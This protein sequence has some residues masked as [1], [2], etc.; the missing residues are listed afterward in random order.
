MVRTNIKDGNVSRLCGWDTPVGASTLFACD[1]T[2]TVDEMRKT[3]KLGAPTY[4]PRQKYN[5]PTQYKPAYKNHYDNAKP[6]K[7]KPFLG[8]GN[9]KSKKKN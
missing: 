5:K 3:R 8:Q 9:K 2:K 6:K 4:T 1:V 7:K